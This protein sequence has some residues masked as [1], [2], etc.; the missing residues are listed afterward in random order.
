MEAFLS[1]GSADELAQVWALK[2]AS[3]APFSAIELDWGVVSEVAAVCACVELEREPASQS[4]LAA[5][6]FGREGRGG[7]G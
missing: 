1:C 5:C 6:G 2:S 3:V 4:Q 7:D